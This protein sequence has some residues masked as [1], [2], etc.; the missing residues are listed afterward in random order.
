MGTPCSMT[1]FLI[2]FQFLPSSKLNS[3]LPFHSSFPLIAERTFTISTRGMSLRERE[4]VVADL[5]NFPFVL[6]VNE[7]HSSYSLNVFLFE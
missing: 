3:N 4:L 1:N 2:C 6:R 5:I 7:M